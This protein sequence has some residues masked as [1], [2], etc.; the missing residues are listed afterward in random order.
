LGTEAEFRLDLKRRW[1]AVSFGGA[2][3]AF[4]EWDEFGDADIRWAGG[5]GFATSLP[6]NS[7]CEW[8]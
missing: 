4:D 7:A 6:E 3:K 1:S 5:A 8:A 2:G